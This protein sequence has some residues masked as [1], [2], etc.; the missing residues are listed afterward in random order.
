MASKKKSIKKIGIIGHG[1]VGSAYSRFLGEENCY[2]IDPA[3]VKDLD[4][5]YR[6]IPSL[7][8]KC[9][10]ICVPTPSSKDGSLDPKIILDV[11]E[12]LESVYKGV[13]VIKSTILPDQLEACLLY[14]SPSPRDYA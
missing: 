4:M 2:V 9:I 3:I 5:S 11:L 1:F 8:L 7:D 6:Q 12:R 10:F 14:T 13:L